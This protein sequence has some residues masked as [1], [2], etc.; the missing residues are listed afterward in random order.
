ME[1]LQ[2]GDGVLQNPIVSINQ[3][4][5]LK[6][7]FEAVDYLLKAGM[8]RRVLQRIQV[9]ILKR[10]LPENRSSAV[11]MMK[12]IQENHSKMDSVHEELWRKLNGET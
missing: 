9:D 6:L 2:Y 8:R 3:L 7:K 5:E 12:T 11:K 4:T 10:I 1:Q